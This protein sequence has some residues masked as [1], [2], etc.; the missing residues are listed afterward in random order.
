MD[1]YVT[2]LRGSETASQALTG[3]ISNAVVGLQFQERVQQQIEHV[4]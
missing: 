3:E 4:V 2:A 1:G